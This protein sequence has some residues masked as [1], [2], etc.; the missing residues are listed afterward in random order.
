MM[1]NDAI[2][3]ANSD[4]TI[5]F[6]LTAYLDTLQFSR[7]LPEHLT[8]SP[9]TGL[10]DMESRL[11]QLIAEYET[12][13]RLPDSSKFFVL[14]EAVHIFDIAAIR[15]CQ[16]MDEQVNQNSARSRSPDHRPIHQ[17]HAA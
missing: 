15:L 16:L 6:L 7:K 4:H 11:E 2:A 13:I 1:I 3:N 10:Q 17:A 9:I 14:V 12:E 8:V 5:Y